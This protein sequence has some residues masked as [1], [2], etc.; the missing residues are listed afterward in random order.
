MAAETQYTTN[1]GMVTISTA[2]TALN[3]NRPWGRPIHQTAQV[4]GYQCLNDN[5]E[6]IAEG[7][8]NADTL[9]EAQAILNRDA[10]HL[11]CTAYL[12]I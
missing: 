11:R 12:L 5:D 3:G 7:T 4:F 10:A 6:I 2:N 8:M 9:E 1:T